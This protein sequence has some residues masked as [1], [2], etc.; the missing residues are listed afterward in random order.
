[1]RRSR[2]F[3]VMVI[4]ADHFKDINDRFGHLE[5]DEVLKKIAATVKRSLR[6]GDCVFRFGGEEFI[7]L[8]DSAGQADAL[9]MAE[10][11][12]RNVA[13]SVHAAG[14]AKVSISIGVATG[15]QQ[16]Q[17]LIELISAAD[18]SLY[19]AK[20]DGRNRVQGAL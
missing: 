12:R 19:Q 13:D 4:D 3:S 9:A 6:A 14:E 8:V 1:M 11:I 18:K 20:A 15:P 17:S 10:S 7:V 5:G 16:G 2:L